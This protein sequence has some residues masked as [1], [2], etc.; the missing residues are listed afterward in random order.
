MKNIK[1]YEGFMDFFKSKDSEEDLIIL[2]YIKRLEKVTG[3]SPYKININSNPTNDSSYK[4]DRYEVVFDDTPIKIWKVLSLRNS[5]FD[6]QSKNL[7]LSKG[8]SMKNAKEFYGIKIQAEE[9]WEKISPKVK[10]IEKLFNLAEKVYKEDKRR[11]KLDNIN[12][13]INPA[14][15]LIEESLENKDYFLVIDNSKPPKHKYLNNVL[16]YLDTTDVYYKIVETNEE[17]LEACNNFNII[18]A[19]ST[20]SDFRVNDEE[21]NEV[22]FSAIENLDCPIYGICFGFQSI[23]KYYGSEISS[24]EEVCGD[25]ILQEF[26]KDNFLFKDVDLSKTKVSVCF[27]DFPLNVPSGFNVIAKIDGKIA[28][29]SNG[30]GRFGTLFHPENSQL[31]F[32]ILDNFIEYCKIKNLA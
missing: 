19:L 13:N 25:I 7:L 24:E 18:G 27:H 30:E 17:L 12:I 16:K 32:T 10:Y 8:L 23:A 28:G 3:L 4:I 9:K 21:T 11:R 15:D 1:T 29:I 20:G 14:A 2:Q 31:T 6:E 22:S 26:D 5:G